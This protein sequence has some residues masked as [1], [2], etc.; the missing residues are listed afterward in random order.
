[1]VF[2]RRR[3]KKPLKTLSKSRTVGAKRLVNTSNLIEQYRS[4]RFK[5]D[6]ADG[7]MMVV[8]TYIFAIYNNNYYIVMSCNVCMLIRVIASRVISVR[9]RVWRI[10]ENFCTFRHGLSV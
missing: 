9:A 3:K 5:G 1:M 10:H 4:D 6:A 2:Y 7:L 8:T